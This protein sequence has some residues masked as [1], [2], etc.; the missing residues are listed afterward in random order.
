MKHSNK[1]L[2]CF[3]HIP[4]HVQIVG[5]KLIMIIIAGSQSTLSQMSPRHVHL[6]IITTIIIIK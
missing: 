1:G 5:R 6:I 2:H 4:T 3:K